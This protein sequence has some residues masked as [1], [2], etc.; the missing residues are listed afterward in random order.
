MSSVHVDEYELIRPLGRG[1]M[2]QVYQAQDMVLGRRVAVKFIAQESPSPSLRERFLVEARA[3]ARLQHPNV[4]SIYRVGVAGAG[5][6]PP[7]CFSPRQ[8]T[9]GGAESP[10]RS[11][12]QRGTPLCVFTPR[13]P[14]AGPPQPWGSR[15]L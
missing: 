2:G 14:Q 9:P 13:A 3:I 15:L 7:P 4:V 8:E 12:A 10:A 6:S 11:S 1:T 5:P